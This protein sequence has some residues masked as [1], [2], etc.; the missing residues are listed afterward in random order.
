[1][2]SVFHQAAVQN[3]VA[4]VCVRLRARGVAVAQFHVAQQED[5]LPRHQ[6]VIEEHHRVHFVEPRAQ[7]VV[8]VGPAEIETFPAQ[9]LD[10]RRVA[11]NRE[12]E[13]LLPC[14][15]VQPVAG[16]RVY[17]DLV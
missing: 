16:D 1:M 11:R 9:E 3:L 6:H 7:R 14:L 5:P 8:E 17:G 10:S 13:G 12:G 4:G 2:N 15:F